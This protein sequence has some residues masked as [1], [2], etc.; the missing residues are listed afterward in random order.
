VLWVSGP[1]LASIAVFAVSVCFAVASPSGGAAR[2]LAAY[3]AGGVASSM[4]D[5][6]AH[7]PAAD[8]ARRAI[9][10]VAVAAGSN[11][12][13]AVTSLAVVLAVT[14]VLGGAVLVGF[15]SRK[16]KRA[17]EAQVRNTPERPSHC[18]RPAP[19]PIGGASSTAVRAGRL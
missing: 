15:F 3:E 10:A 19:R 18:C 11:P 16:P 8:R 1:A 12:T 2:D 4:S 13:N 17:I 14:L 6:A 7:G 9:D 5:G